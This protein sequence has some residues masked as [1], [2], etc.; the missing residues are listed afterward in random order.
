MAPPYQHMQ[1]RQ[2]LRLRIADSGYEER[3]CLGNELSVKVKRVV[4][5]EDEV[6]GLDV[7]RGGEVFVPVTLP[8]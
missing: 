4:L 3:F 7:V 5:A 2:P 8:G 6:G 1:M